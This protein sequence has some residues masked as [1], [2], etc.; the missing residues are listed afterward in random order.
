MNIVKLPRSITL[1]KPSARTVTPRLRVSPVAGSVIDTTSGSSMRPP[2]KDS[3]VKLSKRASPPVI[4]FRLGRLKTLPTPSARKMLAPNA[5]TSLT[6]GKESKPPALAI[7]LPPTKTTGPFATK[8]ALLP[9]TEMFAPFSM[10]NKLFVTAVPI[11][12]SSPPFR[13]TDSFAVRL[14]TE[15]WPSIVTSMSTPGTSMTTSVLPSGTTPVLQLFGSF[16]IPS[17]LI[18]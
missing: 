14:R 13:T 15:F 16:Q 12:S 18:H 17:L 4:E 9:A 1:P 6:F 8:L 10:V 3:I 11:M 2:D 7:K 5:S